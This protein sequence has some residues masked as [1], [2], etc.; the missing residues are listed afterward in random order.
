MLC[1]CVFVC[2]CACVCHMCLCRVCHVCIITCCV[3]ARLLLLAQSG[4]VRR[5]LALKGRAP[6]VHR[7][8]ASPPAPPLHPK[9]NFLLLFMSTFVFLMVFDEL[10][11]KWLGLTRMRSMATWYK[12]PNNLL[13]LCLFL[14]FTKLAGIGAPAADVDWVKS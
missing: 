2:V 8:P 4:N 9:A 14:F 11:R 12:T 1:M 13:F 7:P 6:E 3:R 10:C 5:W